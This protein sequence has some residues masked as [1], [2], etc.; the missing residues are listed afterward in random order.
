MVIFV[1]LGLLAVD[2]VSLVG[3]DWALVRVSYLYILLYFT[4][5]LWQTGAAY[6]VM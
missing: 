6:N 4:K 5:S 2:F 1:S 3:V